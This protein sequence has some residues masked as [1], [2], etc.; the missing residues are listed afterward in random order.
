MCNIRYLGTETAGDVC[1]EIVFEN[2]SPVTYGYVTEPV[3]ASA[4]SRYK[5]VTIV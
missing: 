4:T 2:G 1:G 5:T 3:V